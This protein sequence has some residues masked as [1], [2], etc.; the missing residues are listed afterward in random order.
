MLPVKVEMFIPSKTLAFT[1]LLLMDIF[2]KFEQVKV[3]T[4]PV[5]M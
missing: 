5:L 1:Q 2:T 3:Q 4:L